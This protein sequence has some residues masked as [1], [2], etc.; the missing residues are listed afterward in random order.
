MYLAADGDFLSFWTVFG[1]VISIVV[2]VTIF[3]GIRIVPQND[4]WV[5]ERFGKYRT[6]LGAGLNLV[7]P[8]ID[9]VDKRW[10]MRERP[11]DID[12][13]HATTKDNIRVKIDGVLYLQIV[14]ARLASYGST[15]PHL[16]VTQLAQTTMR[17]Q[18]GRMDLD[19]TLS[20]RDAINDAIV[21]EIN[22]AA[23]PWGLL[24][25]RYEINDIEPPIDMVEDMKRQAKAERER[26]EEETNATAHRN[27]VITRAEGDKEEAK[28]RSEGERIKL[29]NEATGS[30][31]AVEIAAAAEATAVR[32]KAAAEA[33]ALRAIG[34]AVG[35]D[36][37]QLAVTFR[38]ALEA[39]DAQ[40]QIAGE[41]T[42]VLKD[43]DGARAAADTVA[44][45]IAV[46]SVVGRMLPGGGS[47]EEPGAA[48]AAD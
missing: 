16:A 1:I 30:G 12:E 25:K 46:A 6:S 36:D 7:I 13:Q 37:G 15:N 9:K 23:K 42:I 11:I 22:S 47:S 48:V 26:R 27:A 40:A 8:F 2:L 32:V 43:G 34:R 5:V 20:K 24:V 41:S 35:E 21:D 39:I 3:K 38:L 33:E 14:D 45:A 28:L 4:T 29:E 10:D 17:A 44:E 31:R 18:I 19:E